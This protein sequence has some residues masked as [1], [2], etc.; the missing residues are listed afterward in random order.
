[1]CMAGLPDP[2]KELPQ[3]FGSRVA[4]DAIE[5]MVDEL[6]D[7]V[8]D[9]WAP[10]RDDDRY[11]EQFDVEPGR[12]VRPCGAPFAPGSLELGYR[13]HAV[14]AIFRFS[15]SRPC[16]RPNPGHNFANLL[17]F[18]KALRHWDRAAQL[19]TE[20]RSGLWHQKVRACRAEEA[21][22]PTLYAPNRT[23]QALMEFLFPE[24]NP[25]P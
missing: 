15:Y 17:W 5:E 18:S 9:N 19:R 14:L 21:V 8:G 13:S 16:I 4:S 23:H 7:E 11:D 20:D 22:R 24:L 25:L 3:R 2:A 1:M 12:R 6:H 10:V